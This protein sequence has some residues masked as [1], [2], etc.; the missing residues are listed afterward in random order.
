MHGHEIRFFEQRREVCGLYAVVEV[1]SALYRK[2]GVIADH[3]HA[4]V[5]G[6]VGDH[7]AD[8]AQ[9][10]HAQ[11]FAEDLVAYIGRLALFHGLGNAFRAFERLYPFD[12]VHDLSAAEEE[13]ADHEF[14]H[15]I[16][17]G[18]GGVEHHDALFRAGGNGDVVRARA[19]ARHGEQ[20]VV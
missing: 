15:R 12:G 4:E 18:A 14:F 1:Q 10:D 5:G 20:L 13:F 7:H 19:R 17:V 8:G 9:T 3:V 16:G 6:G 2:V 11:R